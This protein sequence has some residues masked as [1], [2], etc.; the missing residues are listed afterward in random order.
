MPSACRLAGTRRETKDHGH[1]V[2]LRYVSMLTSPR[3]RQMLTR[4]RYTER[5]TIVHI[6]VS[7]PVW[8]VTEEKFKLR[9]IWWRKHQ[10][11]NDLL[12]HMVS[13][14][15]TRAVLPLQNSLF[16]TEGL[17][18]TYQR[19]NKRC[20]NEKIIRRGCR[21]PHDNN[22]FKSM[23]LRERRHKVDCDSC[24]NAAYCEGENVS[25]VWK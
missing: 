2:G 8:R 4:A 25:N 19:Q 20:C 22:N 7:N 23:K 24:A 3:K 9:S 6:A 18:T 12:D 14:N 15:K 17:W 10:T 21:K 16:A 13:V 5:S 1:P 11:S